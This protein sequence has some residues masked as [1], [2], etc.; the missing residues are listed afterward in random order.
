MKTCEK[1]HKQMIHFNE[2]SEDEQLQVKQHVSACEDCSKHFLEIRQLKIS[3]TRLQN[4]DHIGDELLNRYSIYL[5]DSK[6]S[7]YDGYKFTDE[8]IVQIQNHVASCR[9]CQQ[10]VDHIAGEYANI[11]NYLKEAGVPDI[12]FGKTSNW[13]KV[14]GTTTKIFNSIAAV[15]RDFV[16]LPK[17]RIIPVSAGSFVVLFIFIWISPLFRGDG[18]IYFQL[19]S[20]EREEIRSIT[21]SPSSQLLTDG[22]Y[23]F[24]DGDYGT[25]ISKLERYINQFSNDS[26]S[27]AYA[28]EI[29]GIA[30]L[31]ESKKSVFGRF[32]SYDSNYLNRGSEHLQQVL[33]L[34]GNKR[35]L[36][37]AFWY[38][39][40]AYI[41]KKEL[42]EATD[43]FKAV[44][45]FKGR[46]Y[47][48][49]Q[50]ILEDLEKLTKSDNF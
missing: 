20:L 19:T 38:L 44:L 25:T 48:A 17:L 16:T 13:A 22:F 37:D 40:K 14:F 28:H 15:I 41:L 3:L 33:K 24:N 8:K 49:A 27:V 50:Q 26:S 7:D 45:Q 43:S 9:K 34:T 31:V 21:R 46:K 47:E 32:E 1:Y 36:E 5:A 18:K 39:G 23:A 12:T 10:T 6:K 42:D 29:L 2:L 35:L 4:E 11:E 30:Y